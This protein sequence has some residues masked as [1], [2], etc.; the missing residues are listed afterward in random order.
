MYA[1]NREIALIVIMLGIIVIAHECT[2]PVRTCRS[3]AHYT[4]NTPLNK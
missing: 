1:Y 2:Y 4:K 3:L